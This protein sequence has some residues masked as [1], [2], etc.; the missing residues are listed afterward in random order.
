MLNSKNKIE[1]FLNSFNFIIY[2]V[3]SKYK[4]TVQLK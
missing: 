4:T 2:F 1:T 3:Y